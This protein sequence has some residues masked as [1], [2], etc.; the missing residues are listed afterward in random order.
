MCDC[1]KDKEWQEDKYRAYLEIMPPGNEYQLPLVLSEAKYLHLSQ[2]KSWF[3]L[4][5]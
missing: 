3:S 4:G 2:G 5:F 1:G